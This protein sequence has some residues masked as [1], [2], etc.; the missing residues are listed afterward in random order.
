MRVLSQTSST[1]PRGVPAAAIPRPVAFTRGLF[2]LV[3]VLS[4]VYLG[5]ALIELDRLGA[6][7]ATNGIR[8]L[9]VYT[10]GLAVVVA[11]TMP[12]FA[13]LVRR[14]RPWSRMA[15]IATCT[16]LI[17]LS[18]ALVSVDAAT[19]RT[20]DVLGL[21]SPVVT[22][23][24]PLLH[25]VT[26][27]FLL[28]AGVGGVVGLAGA[29]AGEYFRRHLQISADDPRLWSVSQLRNI[30]RTRSES[31]SNRPRS[32]RFAVSLDRGSTPATGRRRPVPAATARA[33]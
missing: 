24:F 33:A 3:G 6:G 21:N 1:E 16:A 14:A 26:A 12:S 23:W 19:L 30:Q 2:V 31:A 17:M 7:R 9:I 11:V 18:V 4:A 25:Y 15:M 20:G 28:L 27:G 32:A 5:L 10:M 29:D 8:D 22:A 13:L